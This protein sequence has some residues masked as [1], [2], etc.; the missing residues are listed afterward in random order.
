MHDTN[1]VKLSSSFTLIIFVVVAAAG[2]ASDENDRIRCDDGETHNDVRRIDDSLR[3]DLAN[4]EAAFIADPAIEGCL[5]W[6]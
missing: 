1:R 3:T 2:D 5:Q 4:H 6:K